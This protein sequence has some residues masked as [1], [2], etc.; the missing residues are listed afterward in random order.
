MNSK[1]GVPAFVHSLQHAYRKQVETTGSDIRR[2]L[3][4]SIHAIIS[5]DFELKIFL[6]ML[7][8]SFSCSRLASTHSSD[9][10]NLG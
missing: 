9:T 8:V 3:P 5:E 6:L 7:S 10:H 1:R 4:A 2:R